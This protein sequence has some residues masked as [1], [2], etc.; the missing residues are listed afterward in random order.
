MEVV[1][2]DGKILV[3]YE[4]T[5]TE[6]QEIPQAATPA[7]QPSEIESIEEL[8]LNGLHIEQYRHATYQASDYYAEA[9]RREPNDSRCNNAMGLQ[10][11]RSGQ[12]AKAETYFRRAIKTITSRNPNPYDG[13]AYYNLG[14]SLQFQEKSS[15]AYDA[16][17]KATWNDAWQHNS[18]LQLARID[19]SKNNFSEAFALIEK[20][21]IRNYHSHSARHLK[22]IILRK[23]KN[24]AAAFDCI[25][26]SL[27]IDPFNFGCSF[28]KYLLLKET[29]EH[30]KAEEQLKNLQ[31]LMRN[32]ANNYLEYAFD[33]AMPDV[34]HEAIALLQ[35][36]VNG[37]D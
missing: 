37:N 21:L 15:D 27:E 32:A 36:Y 24:Y 30:S 11:L 9:L 14:I 3:N 28:E 34:L 10:L 13:E 17:Y 23:L 4:A 12:F 26:D 16:F 33:Y 6:A 20:S 2:E 35:L 29:G 7:K 25:K 22:A 18:F 31:S 5:K 1:S 19:V 8:F